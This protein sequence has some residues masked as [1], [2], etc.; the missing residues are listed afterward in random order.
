MNTRIH[1]GTGRW[2]IDRRGPKSDW[3]FLTSFAG[4]GHLE[5]RARDA[6]ARECDRLSDRAELRLVDPHGWL[7]A[8]YR[9]Y[10]V[11]PRP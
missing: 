2:T 3:R 10:G 5:G 9:G 7:V 4:E 1:P 8:Y 6:F 11:R